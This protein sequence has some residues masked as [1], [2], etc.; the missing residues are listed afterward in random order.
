MSI[1]V[2]VR[3]DYKALKKLFT[4]SFLGV[5]G[6]LWFIWKMMQ[7]DGGEKN[8]ENSRDIKKVK[9]DLLMY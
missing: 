2:W 5:R 7:N 9:Q 1:L 8:V 6:E 3:Y 4:V